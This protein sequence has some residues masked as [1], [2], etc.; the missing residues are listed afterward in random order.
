MATP[1]P[2]YRAADL[3]RL[4]NPRSIAIVGAS[5]RAGSFGER[6][7]RNLAQFQGRVHLVNA[8]YR[9]L[10]G[11]PCH[12]SIAALPEVPD[13]AVVAAPLEAVKGLVQECAAAGVGA[14]ILYAAGFAETGKADRIALQ[15]RI[16][17]VARE[18]GVRLVGPNCIGMLDYA[19][20]A[21]I[22]F[23]AVPR[24]AVA[25]GGAAVGIV[26]QSGNLGFA[27]AQGVER[28]VAVSRVLACGNSADVDVADGVAALAEDPACAAIACVFEGM[29]EP[30]RLIAA[31][32][33]A[34]A[35][36]KPLVVYKLATG[37]QGAAAALS[38]T[39]SLAG[40]D[41]AYRAAFG[42]A[43]AIM[44][45]NFDA[46]LEMA[47]FLA[48]A[49]PCRAPGVAVVSTSGG[50]AIM[51]ADKAEVH[52][53]TLPQPGAA[54]KAVLDARIPEFGS[55]RNPVDITAQVLN[56]PESLRA[57][58]DA[59]CAD[60]AYGAV[61]LPNGYAYD[62]ATPRF[63]LLGTL[64]AQHGKAAAVVW[65]TEWL[66][67][68]GA[69]PAEANPQVGLFRSMDR[70][71]AALAA[72]QA[73]AARRAAPPAST[74]RL[75]GPDAAAQAAALVRAA[76]GTTLTEREAKAMLA[77]YGVPV[78]GETLVGDAE[79]AVAAATAL[80]FPVVLK[81]EAPDIPHKTEAGVIRLGLRDADAVREGYAAVMAN[82][83][84]AVPGT[85]INGVLVQPMV[86]Q[87]LE[88]V[89]GARTDPLFGPM[90]V[91][92]LGGIFVELLRDTATAL[93]PVGEEEARA[94]LRGLKGYRLL[95][96]FR[97]LPGV[98]QHALAKII[99]RVSELAADQR[100]LVAEIDV[101]PLICSADRI[102]A[103]DALIVRG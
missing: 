34:W 95:D 81:V 92:G 48:K 47:A 64:A 97:G 15:A 35:A 51:A 57:C 88:I 43:G 20:G 12:A 7:Q 13:I 38:H 100:D 1:R 22:S 16:A 70:C 87:G 101:N 62:F 98:D 2:L 9:S 82:A 91:V 74:A 54:A 103:V 44:V 24:P 61:V 73:R 25:P 11:L 86:P 85:R 26:S 18:G 53:V 49:P 46:L 75:S 84:R 71:F 33:L 56:D 55:A 10:G 102:L 63:A 66:E 19:S 3:A 80:G 78:V 65:L 77:A 36:D 17:A 42:R 50:A 94:M 5:E 69:M 39:G 8:R 90:V 58:T 60:P 52:G 30:G 29:A 67:G 99:C 21:T 28:G 79:A 59:L 76:G 45:E 37:E 40:S 68:P 4:L 93:A 83:V 6:T 32:E 23:A 72:W 96:G 27:L 89:V 31:A 41:A 14:A